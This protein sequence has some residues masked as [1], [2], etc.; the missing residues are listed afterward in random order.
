[1]QIKDNSFTKVEDLKM[2]ND[3]VKKFQPSIALNR[4]KH[5]MDIFFKFDQGQKSTRSKLLKHKWFT[6]QTEIST[7]LIFKSAKF[8]NKYFERIH[9]KY[10]TIDSPIS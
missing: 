9:S 8:A 10:H 7:N 6:Y 4:I 1:M 5:W 3:L 2:L